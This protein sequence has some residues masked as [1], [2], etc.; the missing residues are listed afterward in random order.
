MNKNA[1]IVVTGAAGFIGSCLVGFLNNHGYNNLILVDEFTRADKAPNLDGKTFREKVEREQFFDWL[2]NEAN[3]VDFIYHIGARTDTT[4]FDYAVHQKLNV[5]Y[6]QKIWSYCVWNQVPLVYASS[7]AT[8]GAGELGYNDDHEVPFNLKPLN[9]YGVSKNE[10]DKWAL[11]QPTHPPFW[12]GLKFF[13]V[14]GPNENHKGRMASVI[15]HSFNQIKK[16]GLVKLFKSHRPDFKDGQQLRD[17]VYVKDLLNVCYWLM[18][19]HDATGNQLTSG[20]YNLGTGKARSFEALVKAT[21]AGLDKE[22]NIQYIDMP[23]DIRDKYQYFT[24]ANM[25]KLIAAGYKIPFHTLEEGVDDYVR[26]YLSTGKY[27]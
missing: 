24:E 9:P 23:E 21:Y 5:E 6:S 7:A 19:Q 22:A 25:Q 13:N 18:E 17:F 11:Q 15:W 27:Y 12:A 1:T 26:N 14:Y 2:G 4:E 20:L 3:T 16:D 10:F 8:Y